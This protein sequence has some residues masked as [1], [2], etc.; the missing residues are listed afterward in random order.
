[1]Q[2]NATCGVPSRHLAQFLATICAAILFA[3]LLPQSQAQAQAE[4]ANEAILY[5]FWGDGCP[6][7]AAEKAFLADLAARHPTLEIRDYEV[8]N[9]QA[10]Q[11]V[12]W[13]MAQSFGFEPEAVPTTFLGDRY[14]VGFSD[15]IGQ[16]IEQAVDL[17]VAAGCRDAG[18][19]IIAPATAATP[20]PFIGPVA[21]AAPATAPAAVAA[22]SPSAAAA[23]ST[24][25]VPLIGVISLQDQSLI[26]STAIIAFVDGF[27]PCS[28][29]ALTV[30]LAITL[31]TG[32]RRK[33]AII[34]LVYISVTA[35]IY[36]LFIAGLF[37]A[38]TFINLSGWLRV[39]V[40]AVALA[41]A[42]INIKDYFF[43]KQGASLTIPDAQKPGLYRKMRALADPNR[44][45]ASLIGGT[46][47]LAA[48]VSLVE[49][50]CTAGFPMLWT[51]LLTAQ[52][53]GALA[54]LALLALYLLI[55]QLDELLIFFGAV[56]TM[57]AARLEE[58]HGRALKLASGMLMLALAIVMLID[59]SWM[60]SLG[61][62]LLV[63]AAAALATLAVIVVVQVVLPRMGLSIG[64]G[65]KRPDR[66]K[67]SRR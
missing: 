21:G 66:L 63:F 16:Q 65:K 67:Q 59:P 22:P 12:M 49:F 7:C 20:G 42:A 57:K 3:V 5:L 1:M 56:A 60:N 46:I 27:N 28:L 41:F 24:L 44:S 6:H 8:W 43:F 9:D 48:G 11:L 26:V 53:V 51:N 37:T 40:A 19:G 54:F 2:H 30:L 35:L 23:A 33:V 18:A 15:Q 32:S 10:N 58:K 17:C 4:D 50:S 34:G 25:S 14:W 55:Y 36:A 62:A 31:H 52:G 45:T 38:F 47:V 13:R 64:V 29:W 61:N 39:I